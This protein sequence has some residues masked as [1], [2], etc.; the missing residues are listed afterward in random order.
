VDASRLGALG[1]SYGASLVARVATR[2]RRLRAVALHGVYTSARDQ[3]NHGYAKWGVLT[4]W[5]A[6]W[7]AEWDGL[8]LD[9]LKPLEVVA[10]IAPTPLLV[11]AGTTDI[12]VPQYM[13]RAVFEAARE[14]KTFLSIEGAGHGEYASVAPGAY[15]ECLTGFFDRTLA[16]GT[17]PAR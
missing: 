5:P 4:Q 2:E 15:F 6:V 12:V 9:D 17:D 7:G 10:N 3:L 8:V 16:G 13:S 14:P 1:F 11:V